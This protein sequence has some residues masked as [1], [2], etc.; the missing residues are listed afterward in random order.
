MKVLIIEDE[1]HVAMLV[2]NIFKKQGHQV[3][4]IPNGE[5][6]LAL[7]LMNVHDVILLDIGLPQMDGFEVLRRLRDK[8]IPTPIMMLTANTQDTV[9]GL[10][11]GADDYLTKPF[12]QDELMARVDALTRR[13]KTLHLE[14][15]FKIASLEFNPRMLTVSSATKTVHLALK[16]SQIL[17]LLVKQGKMPL[18]KDWLIA[19]VWHY[20]D[21]ATDE[22]LRQHISRLRKKIKQLDETVEI[23]VMRKNGY[24][25]KVK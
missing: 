21:G 5:D 20:D 7:G 17:E 25:L 23:K 16:E 4:I 2:E 13:S 10:R 19:H 3:E 6:G 24:L 11:S 14:D 9:K 12:N 8:K 15:T 22:V 18:S 1:E